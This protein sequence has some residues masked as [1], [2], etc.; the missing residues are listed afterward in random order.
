[1][2]PSTTHRLRTIFLANFCGCIALQFAWLAYCFIHGLPVREE[3]LL[4]QVGRGTPAWAM[5]FVGPVVL[6]GYCVAH[7]D[8][9]LAARLGAA[10]VGLGGLVWLLAVRWPLSVVYGNPPLVFDTQTAIG[11]Y[12]LL[13]YAGLAA[14]WR[15]AG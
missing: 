14:F 5:V 8:R 2:A 3:F 9:N 13:S 6:A 12:V 10:V 11:I 7:P 1:M 15:R 4:F